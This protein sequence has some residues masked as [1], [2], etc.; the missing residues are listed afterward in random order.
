MLSSNGRSAISPVEQKSDDTLWPTFLREVRLVPTAKEHLELRLALASSEAPNQ[1]SIT[2][3]DKLDLELLNT[4]RHASGELD[5]AILE[6]LLRDQRVC[7]RW[8]GKSIEFPINVDLCVFR[9]T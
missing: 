2:P 7:V 4:K 3:V 1:F 9:G 8:D 6:M 5:P